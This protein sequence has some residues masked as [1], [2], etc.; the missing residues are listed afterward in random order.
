MDREWFL[1]TG[2]DPAQGSQF[3]E[4]VDVVGMKMGEKNRVDLAYRQAHGIE[5]AS[6][7]G[8]GVDD[9]HIVSGKYRYAAA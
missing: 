2:A 3:P 7:P 5:V 8:T 4:P 1:V 6:P 9:H